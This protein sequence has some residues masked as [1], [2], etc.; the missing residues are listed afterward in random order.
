[1]Q[2]KNHTKRAK[3]TVLGLWKYEWFF[4]SKR[5]IIMEKNDNINKNPQLN[6]KKLAH[7]LYLL[8]KHNKKAETR[9]DAH[10]YSTLRDQVFWFFPPVSPYGCI[11]L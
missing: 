8:N 10:T 7:I 3:V 4:L 2:R 5:K 11:I 6:K 9:N 1:M